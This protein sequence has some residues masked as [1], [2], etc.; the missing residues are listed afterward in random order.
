MLSSASI[1]L[2]PFGLLN[3]F[4]E[5]FTRCAD[6]HSTAIAW[7]GSLLRRLRRLTYGTT[8]RLQLVRATKLTP[9]LSLRLFNILDYTSDN[10][11]LQT[12]LPS[13]SE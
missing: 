13:S 10:L 3:A 2:S 1:H 7:T 6:S 9:K 8:L 12:G 4:D 11:E 5:R